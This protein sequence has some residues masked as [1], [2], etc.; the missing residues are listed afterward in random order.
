MYT[1]VRESMKTISHQIEDIVTRLPSWLGG[2]DSTYQ[3]RGHRFDPWSGKI[4]DA[5]G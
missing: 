3:C 1:D 4:P 2:K 5:M